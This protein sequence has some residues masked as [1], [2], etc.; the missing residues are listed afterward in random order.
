MKQKINE[1]KRMQ[2]LAGMLN[3]NDQPGIYFDIE[4]DLMH[5]E[6]ENTDDQVKYLQDVINFCNSKIAELQANG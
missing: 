1:I 6:F 4:Q 5:G 2:Q 3:E